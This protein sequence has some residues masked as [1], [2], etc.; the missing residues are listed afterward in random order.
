MDKLA[1]KISD[2]VSCESAA[3]G[4]SV[5][6]YVG[7]NYARAICS[8][9]WCVAFLNHGDCFAAPSCMERHLESDEVFV[10]LAGS[11][12]LLIGENQRAVQMAPGRGYNVSRGTWHQIVTQPG[13][14][15]LVVENA[16]TSLENSER[17]PL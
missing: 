12:T 1:T 17:I 2:G 11:A 9:G 4:L 13:A 10:L 7:H 8:G 6:S 14:R 5:V 16:D 3:D 15:C